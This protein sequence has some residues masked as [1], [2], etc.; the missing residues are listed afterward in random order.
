MDILPA[1]LCETKEELEAR[2]NACNGL[3]ERVHVDFADGLFVPHVLP[4]MAVFNSLQSRLKFEVHLMV[5]EPVAWV[6]E[7]LKNTQIETIII[8]VE[9][10]VEV[11]A[12][13]ALVHQQ[14]RKI[15]LALKPQTLGVS[16][17]RWLD[18]LDQVLFL[19]VEPG[20]NGSAVVESVVDKIATFH[21]RYPHIYVEV[22]GGVSDRNIAKLAKAGAQR[23]AVGSYLAQD[24][25]SRL[26][27]L[28]TLVGDN[29]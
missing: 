22:D 27:L 5:Q 10:T 8:H 17:N 1:I 24:M 12:L 2:L 13:I 18:T 16:I 20:F 7:A 15:G 6:Q 19:L 11:E 23:V 9:A 26:K 4:D 28:H 25:M 29:Q 21:Q 14:G 3:V